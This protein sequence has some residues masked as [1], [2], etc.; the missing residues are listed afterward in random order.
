YDPLDVVD[1]NRPTSHIKELVKN[2]NFICYFNSGSRENWRTYAKNYAAGDYGASWDPEWEGEN[3]MNVESGNSR[4]I[5]EKETTKTAS[6]T[7]PRSE[8]VS[9]F[10]FIASVAYNNDMAIRLKNGQAMIADNL[11]DIDFVVNKQCYKYGECYN[12][13][14][15]TKANKAVVYFEYE[16][17]SFTVLTW[18]TLICL[19]CLSRGC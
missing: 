17:R 7:C 9:F 1:A 12:Y 4:E 8:Y 10:K 19:L 2:K 18:Q 16:T 14:P 5:I 11:S 3:W 15:T 6:A 13:K